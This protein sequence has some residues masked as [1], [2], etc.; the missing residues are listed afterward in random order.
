M[1]DFSLY[2]AALD[3]DAAWHNAL[4]A[5][6]GHRNAGDARYGSAGVETPELLA[7]CKAKK[8]ADAAWL[9][10]NSHSAA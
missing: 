1:K 7:L 3:A 10:S 4:V 2:Y 8:A 5:R 9:D 6:Y